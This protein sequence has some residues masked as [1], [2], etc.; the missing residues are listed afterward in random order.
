MNQFVAPPLTK[1]NK[2]ILIAAGACFLLNAILTAVGGFSLVS[3]LGLS[4]SGLFGGMI[5]QLFTY[6]FV[7]TQL[8][9]FIFNGLVVWFIGSE[10]EAQWGTKVYVRFLLLTLV[11]VGLIFSLIGLLFFMGAPMYF[12][13]LH[14]LTGLNFAL[15]IAYSILYPDRQMAFMMMFPMKARTFCWILAGIEAYMAIFTSLKTAW[16]HL[17][18]MGFAWL[19]INFQNNPLIRR[20]LNSSF[21]KSKSAGKKHLYVV[22]DDDQNP[23]KYWQ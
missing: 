7:E 12:A 13:P 14:G 11:G 10:L 3:L 23:P 20:V 4:G 8:M 2:L 21:K 18:A 1:V 15:L 22:K 19:I 17:L 9:S 6:P 5:F 16:A